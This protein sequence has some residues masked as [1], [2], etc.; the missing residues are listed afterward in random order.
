MVRLPVVAG[1]FYP[2]DPAALTEQ[3]LALCSP[4]AATPATTRENCS[5]EKPGRGAIACMV[6]HAGYRFS[7]GVAGSVYAALQLPRRFLIIGPRHFPRG[8]QEAILSA[9]GWQTP[10]G[11]AKIDSDLAG[12]LKRACPA[13]SEDKVAHEHEHAIEVQLPFLQ[14][15]VGDMSFVPIALGTVSYSKLDALGQAIAAVLARQSEPVLIVASSDM[16][17]YESDEITRR[18]DGLALERLLA[19]D[20]RGLYDVVRNEGIS[21]CGVGPAVSAMVAARMLGANRADLLRYATSGDVSERDVLGDR[22]EVV[23]YAGVVIE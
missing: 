12:E 17:H 14:H 10:L 16:N 3:I 1:R 8:R 21:M 9:G 6:P 4:N 23:G 13:L 19:L 15:L 11:V 22:D 2:K 20:P 7:G 5:N 18:K